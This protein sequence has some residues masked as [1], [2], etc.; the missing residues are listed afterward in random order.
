MLVVF[1]PDRSFAQDRSFSRSG[2]EEVNRVLVLPSVYHSAAPADDASSTADRESGEAG[3]PAGS[4]ASKTCIVEPSR[5]D[6]AGGVLVVYGDA[7]TVQ[8]CW[9]SDPTGAENSEAETGGRAG[10]A[11]TDPSIG[12]AGDYQEQ[13][14]GAESADPGVVARM[15]V[16]VVGEPIVPYYLPRNYGPS[17]SAM[18]PAYGAARRLFPTSRP[19][20]MP[21]VGNGRPAWMPRPMSAVKVPEPMMWRGA[22]MRARLLQMRRMERIRRR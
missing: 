4:A 11:S 15:P 20:W 18:T 17:A 9:T 3:G 22:S 8:D 19:A 1:I 2:W 10:A 14:S 16:V 6:G 21:P 12:T 13:Q 5:P 7:D